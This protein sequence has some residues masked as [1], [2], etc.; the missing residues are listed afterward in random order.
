MVLLVCIDVETRGTVGGGGMLQSSPVAKF[1][2]AGS[3]RF[4]FLPACV[5]LQF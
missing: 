5:P 4:N 2:F 3:R 1:F